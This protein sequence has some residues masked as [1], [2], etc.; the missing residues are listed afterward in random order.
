MPAAPVSKVF[1]HDVPVDEFDSP[2]VDL[3]RPLFKQ[4]PHSIVGTDELLRPQRADQKFYEPRPV[5]FREG[6]SRSGDLVIVQQHLHL[7]SERHFDVS[8]LQ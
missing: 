3:L 4:L 6:D 7:A 1:F 8:S 5:S 2:F